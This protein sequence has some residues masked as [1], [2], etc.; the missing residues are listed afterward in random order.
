MEAEH[1]HVVW[2]EAAAGG[3]YV[4][5]RGHR[6]VGFGSGSFTGVALRP[7]RKWGHVARGIDEVQNTI[8]GHHQGAVSAG[9]GGV[10]DTCKCLP[11]LPRRAGRPRV[12]HGEP[13]EHERAE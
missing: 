9:P 2:R 1:E 4:V 8:A 10:E 13:C 6:Q 3:A 7:S 12:E 11:V 5:T